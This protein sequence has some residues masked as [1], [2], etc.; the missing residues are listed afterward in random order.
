MK[1]RGSEE[2]FVS[3]KVV[4]FDTQNQV[5]QA[6]MLLLDEALFNKFKEFVSKLNWND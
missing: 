4:G 2:R 3:F 1:Q 5:S 6:E